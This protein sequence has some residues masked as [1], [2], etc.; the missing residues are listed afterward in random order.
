MFLRVYLLQFALIAV[1]GFPIVYTNL[2][3]AGDLGFFAWLGLLVWLAGLAFEVIGDEQLRR[4]KSKPGSKGRL[5]TTG[6]WAWTRHPNYFGEALSWW[7]MFLISL[8]GGIGRFWLVFSPMVITLLL[9]RVS[10]VPLLEKKYEGREDWEAYKRRTAR[11]F[12]RPPRD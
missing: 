10:G 1:I 9:T 3:G 2:L 7:G 6:L 11:F 4:F 12:P 8:S 5:M